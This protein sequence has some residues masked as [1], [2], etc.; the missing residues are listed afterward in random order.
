MHASTT[1]EV[2]VFDLAQVLPGG[3]QLPARMSALPLGDGT[4]ALVSPIP[5]DDALAARIA[6]LGEVRYLIAPN[7]LHHL[8]LGQAAQRYPGAQ[9]IAPAGLARKRPDLRIDLQLQDGLPAALGAAVECMHIAGA[10]GMDEYV[11][12]HRASRTLVVTDLVFNIRKPRG[13]LAHAVLFCVGCHGRLAQSRAWR[14][15][16]K[17][18]ALAAISIARVLALPIDT[19]IMAHGEVERD[20]AGERLATALRWLGTPPASPHAAHEQG[21]RV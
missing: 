15:F 18:R 13:V 16:V 5:I 20:R 7:L 19:L 12:Y 1:A 2:T 14:F 8:Y 11:F 17:D 4:L 6:A 10:P 3:F 21:A 9:V